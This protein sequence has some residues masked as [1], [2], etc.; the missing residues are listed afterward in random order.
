MLTNDGNPDGLF[1]AA[2]MQSGS[3]VLA[4]DITQVG[5][6]PAIFTEV[7]R[8]LRFRV[9]VTMT[10]SLNAQDARAL[11]ILLLVYARYPMKY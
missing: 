4:G 5:E 3:P 7:L 9:S 1:R 10:I 2:F 11:L 6:H 8:N